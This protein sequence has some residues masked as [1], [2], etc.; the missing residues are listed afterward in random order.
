[1]LRYSDCK[2]NVTDKEEF[3]PAGDVR[4]KIT[5]IVNTGIVSKVPY[6]EK[7]LAKPDKNAVYI[8]ESE[9]LFDENGSWNPSGVYLDENYK[10]ENEHSILRKI[11]YDLD[12][13][14]ARMFYLFDKSA[15][16]GDIKTL[17]LDFFVDIPQFIKKS[18]NV[19]EVG[20]SSKRNLEGSYTWKIDTAS[21]KEGWNSL[22]LDIADA[23][24]NGK[25]SLD[26]IKTVFI[27]F[28]EINL[29]SED[30]ETVVIG[31]DNLR[32]LSNN[33]NKTLKING[34]EDVV[35][36][37]S[38]YE[39]T[40]D[41]EFTTIDTEISTNNDVKP[42]AKSKTIYLK[43][44]VNKVVTNYVLAIIIL[45]AEFVVYAVA[46]TLVVIITVARKKK[47]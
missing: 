24:K 6:D 38:V 32:Y 36:E 41:E 26:E 42:R 47:K 45:C 15:D 20:L 19:I 34:V 35:V 18:G 16:L 22:S 30:Y 2:F 23:E 7:Q 10:T 44:T 8:N 29:S 28:A 37:D 3:N 25:V 13:S 9:N 1:M 21:L 40:F 17:K 46:S 33:G 39:D 31:V 43:Q 14:L 12:T 5:N 4:V 11:S 27:R